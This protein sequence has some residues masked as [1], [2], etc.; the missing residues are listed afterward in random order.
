MIHLRVQRRQ[1]VQPPLTPR[2]RLRCRAGRGG[3]LGGRGGRAGERGRCAGAGPG[4]RGRPGEG[5]GDQEGSDDRYPDAGGQRPL[6]APQDP[7]KRL[8]AITG[9]GRPAAG[10]PGGAAGGPGSAPGGGVAGSCGTV[11]WGGQVGWGTAAG[12][13]AA[14]AGGGAP[15]TCGGAPDGAGMP[16]DAGAADG[17]GDGL[18]AAGLVLAAGWA[19]AA[20]PAAATGS[21]PAAGWVASARQVAVRPGRRAAEPLVRA[22]RGARRPDGRRRRGWCPCWRRRLGSFIASSLRCPSCAVV[23]DR[24]AVYRRRPGLP[25]C[26]HRGRRGQAG[27]ARSQ[28]PAAGCGERDG[29]GRR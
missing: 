10:A 9:D 20:G 25:S 7:A 26:G 28:G 14:Q 29:G 8:R 2:Q 15:G 22:A 1:A 23:A 11:G 4:G 12:W 21:G 13:R 19:G 5:G 18:E 17:A 27:R 24:T 16:D 6:P 3:R